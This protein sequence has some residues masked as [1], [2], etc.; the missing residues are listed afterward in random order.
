MDD[1]PTQ[2]ATAHHGPPSTGELSPS[3]ASG[4]EPTGHITKTARTS[5]TRQSHTVSTNSDPQPTMEATQHT[6]DTREILHAIE[7]QLAVNPAPDSATPSAQ[8]AKE[9][10]TRRALGADD[11][12]Q[13]LRNVAREKASHD[14]DEILAARELCDQLNLEWRYDAPEV[15]E[16]TTGGTV[17]RS[18]RVKRHPEDPP[19]VIVT[20]Y[21][22]DDPRTYA[23]H[24]YSLIIGA[25]GHGDYTDDATEAMENHDAKVRQHHREDIHGAHPEL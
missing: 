23:T 3:A 24:Y 19:L 16:E 8:Q 22:D 1:S 18:T 13:L 15:G 4:P 5:T 2:R 7:E 12:A 9:D 17:I 6:D 11:P 25:Y 10:V 20:R 14:V 21:R